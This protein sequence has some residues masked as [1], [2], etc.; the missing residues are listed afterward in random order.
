MATADGLGVEGYQV[1][2]LLRSTHTQTIH[3]SSATRVNV[4]A[5]LIIVF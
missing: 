2:L 4:K 5:A 3:F 1:F